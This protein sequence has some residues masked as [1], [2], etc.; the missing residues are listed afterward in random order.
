MLMDT[1]IVLAEVIG[2]AFVLVGLT[3]LNKNYITAVMGDLERSKGLTWLTGVVTFVLGAIIVGL[4]N[5]WSSDWQVVI[6]IIGWLM[7]LKGAFIT[8][9]PNSSMSFYRKVGSN[10]LIVVAGIVA[11]IIGLVLFYMGLTA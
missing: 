4:Y 10:A 2:A 11:I 6:T 3:T 1:S 5:V 9:L 7:I 8:L